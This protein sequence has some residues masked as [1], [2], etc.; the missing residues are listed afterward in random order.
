MA[1]PDTI[2]NFRN[3]FNI[4]LFADKDHVSVRSAALACDRIATLDAFVH[5]FR[6]KHFSSSFSAI[7]GLQNTSLGSFFNHIHLRV[8]ICRLDRTSGCLI[9]TS[10]LFKSHVVQ[11]LLAQLDF[12]LVELD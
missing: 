11:C 3:G 9:S 6:I 7:A 2:R 12:I 1:S 10:L 8:N 4:D 5:T